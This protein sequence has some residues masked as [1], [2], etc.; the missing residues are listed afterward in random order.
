MSDPGEIPSDQESLDAWR[1]RP[2]ARTLRPLIDR[3]LPF[4]YSSAFRRTGDATRASDVTRAVFLVLARR[5]RKLRK[6]TVLAGWLFEVTAVAY[7]KLSRVPGANSASASLGGEGRGEGGRIPLPQRGEGQ[8]EGALSAPAQTIPASPDLRSPSPGSEGGLSAGT[9]RRGFGRMLIRFFTLGRAGQRRDGDIAPALAH[10]LDRALGRMPRRLRNAVLLRTLLN[11]D[12]PSIASILRIRETRAKKRV[13]RASRKLTRRLSR[14]GVNI[15]ADTLTATY[16]LEACATP[17]ESLAEEILAAIETTLDKRPPL[18][19]ARRVLTALAWRR[20]R[21][22]FLIGVPSAFALLIA[23]ASIGWY[24]DSLTGHSRL[25][26]AFLFWSVRH[27]AKTTPGLMQAARPWPTNTTAPRLSA[28]AIQKPADLYQSTNIWLAHLKFSAEQWKAI[29]P[30]RIGPLP[31]FLQSDGTV[32]LRNPKAQRSGLA[33]V[34]GLDF[35]W[36]HADLELGGRQFTNVASR[37]KGNGTYLTSL[38]G[39]KR[40]FKVSLN[41]YTKGQKLAGIDELNFHN[42]IDDYS[43]MS[44]ALAY[45]FFREAGVPAPRTAYAYLSISVDHQWQHRPLGLYLMAE[46]VNGAFLAERFGAKNIPLFKPVTLELFSDLGTNWAAYA[47]IYDLKTKATPEQLRRLID[48]AHLLSHASDAEFAERLGTF[49]DL[50]EF[51]RFLAVEVL[52]ATYDSLFT[53]GQNFYLYLDP[54]SGK[55]GFIPWDL[56]LAWGG[57]FLLGNTKERERASIWHPWVGENRFLQRVMAVEEFRKIYRAHLEEFLSQLFV[58]ER[59]YQRIDE[60]AAILRP[61][62][63]AESDFRLA[64]FDQATSEKPIDRPTVKSQGGADRPAH[65]LKRFIK[66]RAISVRHQL[67]G[68]SKGIILHRQQRQ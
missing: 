14:R 3:Y 55:L 21:R 34:L 12:W 38:Y 19:L 35:N 68:K 51:A 36:V 49:L 47:D 65:Q 16:Q 61:A 45:E 40:P 17:P 20:V 46:A 50:D 43:S 67:D 22:R 44:D 5:A 7:K 59:L 4:V 11:Y 42:L 13:A 10:E 2:R 29:E 31:N 64:K 8:G 18:Q 53:N 30:T 41:R 62:V 32:L 58:P 33:G 9:R 60:L 63:A 25:L 48:F 28:A 54:K 15:H 26:T 57:F 1:R 56:D 23:V 27:E 66:N 39:S 52:L 6:K 24:I 37:F